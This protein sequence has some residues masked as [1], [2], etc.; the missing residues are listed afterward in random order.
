MAV[1]FD[2]A[3]TSGPPDSDA[4]LSHTVGVAGTNPVAIGVITE[5]GGVASSCT[6]TFGGDAMT[7]I[8]AFTNNQGKIFALTGV[9]GTRDFVVTGGGAN[10]LLAVIS[11][12]GVDQDFPADTAGLQSSDTDGDLTVSSEANEVVV[13]FITNYVGNLSPDQTADTDVTVRIDNDGGVCGA[14]NACPSLGI[15][16]MPGA[17]SVSIGWTSDGSNVPKHIAFA[18]QVASPERPRLERY[19]ENAYVSAEA[20]RPILRDQTTG[21]EIETEEIDWDEWGRAEGPFLP[22]MRQYSS[23]VEKP[24]SFYVQAVTLL[25]NGAARIQSAKE[26]ALESLLSRLGG[27]GI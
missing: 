10:P 16:E 26:S 14:G 3:S 27:R 6:A 17:A 25:A 20:G 11:Y 23:L 21:R 13:D 8:A 18:L 4:T 19:Y 2:A 9:T 7:E 1:T 5:A 22:T 24:S 15:G 12:Y